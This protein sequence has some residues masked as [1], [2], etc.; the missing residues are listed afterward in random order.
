MAAMKQQNLNK[1]DDLDKDGD[2]NFANEE[3][4]IIDE[5]DAN[6]DDQED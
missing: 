6:N 5:V 2:V 3:P 1:Q 4:P